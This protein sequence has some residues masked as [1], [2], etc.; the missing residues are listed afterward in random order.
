MKPQLK[1]ALGFWYLYAIGV[2]TIIG[3][4]IFTFAGYALS[5][6]GPSSLAVFAIMGFCLLCLVM[7]FGELV[8]WLPT[9][10]GPEVW[11][12]A[13]V[14]TPWGAVSSLLFSTGWILAGGAT[15]LAVG[16]YTHNFLMLFGVVLLPADL[17]ITVISIVWIT[18]FA[19]LNIRG[20]DVAARTQLFLVV[21]LLVI[22]GAYGAYTAPY[23]NVGYFVPF[24]PKGWG[25]TL[26]AVPVAVYAYMGASTVLFAA[27]EATS[28]RMIPR[29]LFWVSLT[30]LLVYCGVLWAAVGTLEPA[31][32][33]AFLESLFVSS[34][35]KFFGPFFANLVN[36]AAWIAAATCLLM[37]TIYQ[38]TRDLYNL[39]RSG[40]RVPRWFGELHPRFK[41]PSKCVIF[42]WGIVVLLVLF[43]QWRG[44]R[45]VYKL[46]S[47]EVVWV[48]CISLLL[49]LCAAVR[50]RVLHPRVVRKLSWRVPLWPLTP[51]VGTVGLGGCL[52][53][54]FLDIA[55]SYGMSV[56]AFTLLLSLLLVGGMKSLVLRIL[57]R[58]P[59]GLRPSV[60]FEEE[61]PSTEGEK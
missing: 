17:W 4:G 57:P 39:G 9:S 11:V 37:G 44:H 20:V 5:T 23:V 29:V 40:Y 12:R 33:E 32:I 26:G 22:M 15:C 46:L 47:Y 56:S 41:T 42:I 21:L 49:T 35:N 8:V 24:M 6:A 27:E 2:G 52:L 59:D 10:G 30:S 55:R 60:V 3:D 19:Y 28:P 48:W 13:L 7:S 54:I 45:D 51:L 34:S 31:E 61:R 14:G 58:D 43:G 18:L 1:K 38:P 50:L 36:F 16:A 25:G 53:S